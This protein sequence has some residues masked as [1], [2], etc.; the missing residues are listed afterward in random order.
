[1][2]EFIPFIHYPTMAWFIAKPNEITLENA[3]CRAF[4]TE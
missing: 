4:R 2:E 1:M 3:I